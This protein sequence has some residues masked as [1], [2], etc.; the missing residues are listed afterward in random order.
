MEETDELCHI[1]TRA[2]A[3]QSVTV[4]VH[5]VEEVGK[6]LFADYVDKRL[7]QKDLTIFHPLQKNSLPLLG[8]HASK[9]AAGKIQ[10]SLKALKADC[11]L[12]ARLYVACQNRDG[13]LDDFFV[14]KISFNHPHCHTLVTFV[15]ARS[16]TL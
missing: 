14:M 5:T 12:F 8:T 15:L 6:K 2:V 4:T 13:N 9:P 3:A 10:Q 11:N 7:V 16:L 1:T